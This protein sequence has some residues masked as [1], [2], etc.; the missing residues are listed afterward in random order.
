MAGVKPD[1]ITTQTTTAS[2]AANRNNAA[3]ALAQAFNGNA[4]LVLEDDVLLSPHARAWIEYLE[5]TT[6]DV[7]TLYAP[8]GRFYPPDV[9]TYVDFRRGVPPHLYGVKPMRRLEQWFG[10]QAVWIPTRWVESILANPDFRR[11]ERDPLGPWDHA[12]GKHLL[13]NDG[14]MRVTIPNVV[15]HQAPPSVVPRGQR[16]RRH[17]TPVFDPAALPPAPGKG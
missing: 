14:M 8:E 2:N 5:A 13:Q 4:V 16:D 17:T 12:L 10:A 9:R 7:V 3:A 15:Q 1:V 11:E 6:T